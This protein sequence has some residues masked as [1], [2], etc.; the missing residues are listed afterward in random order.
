MLVRGGGSREDLNP[1]DDERVVRAIR[2]CPF[3]VVTGVGHEID[4]TLSD[5]AADVAALQ[6]QND[7]FLIKLTFS[8]E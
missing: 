1:F 7:F 6:L 3:P 8:V 5:L 4:M 2:S